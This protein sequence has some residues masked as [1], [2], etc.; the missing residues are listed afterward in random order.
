MQADSEDRDSTHICSQAQGLRSI[1]QPER[2][3]DWRDIDVGEKNESDGTERFQGL[4]VLRQ[5]QNGITL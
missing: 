3:T 5:S 2:E 4:V 1:Q